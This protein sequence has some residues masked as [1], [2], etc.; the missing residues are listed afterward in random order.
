MA[1]RFLPNIKVA[2]RGTSGNSGE[3]FGAFITSFQFDIGYGNEKSTLSM[4][5]ENESGSYP[6]LSGYKS[7]LDSYRISVDRVATMYM[8]LVAEEESI[9]ATRSTLTLSFVDGSH[10]LDRIYIGLLGEHDYSDAAREKTTLEAEIPIICEGCTPN[11]FLDKIKVTVTPTGYKYAGKAINDIDFANLVTRGVANPDELPVY[12]SKNLVLPNKNSIVKEG[13][14]IILGDEG[15]GASDCSIKTSDYS[16]TQLQSVLNSLNPAISTDIKI[17]AST[18]GQRAINKDLNRFR[19]GYTGTLRNVLKNWC[20]DFGVSFVYDC[21]SNTPN[22]KQIDLGN[23]KLSSKISKIKNVAKNIKSTSASEAVVEGITSSSTLEG[24]SKKF[25]ASK[26]VN[27]ETYKSHNSTIYFQTLY[28]GIRIQD[29]GY[30]SYGRTEQEFLISCA[31]AKYNRELRTIYNLGLALQGFM[32]IPR[33]GILRA[34]GFLPQVEIPHLLKQQVLNS[35]GRSDYMQV[36]KVFD[37]TGT[38]NFLMAV[39]LYSEDLDNQE[40]EYEK[41]VAET[42]IGQHF[43]TNLQE[44]GIPPICPS[45]EQPNKVKL[46]G[47]LD[48]KVQKVLAATANTTFE[49]PGGSSQEGNYNFPFANILRAPIPYNKFFYDPSG[50]PPFVNIFSRRNAAYYPPVDVFNSFFE[51]YNPMAVGGGAN[52][53]GEP[54]GN[55]GKSLLQFLLPKYVDLN[56]TAAGFTLKSRFPWNFIG[57]TITTNLG[58]KLEPKLFLAPNAAVI[59]NYVRVSPLQYA[60]NPVDEGYMK[61][62]EKEQPK[63][64]ECSTSSFIC[65]KQKSLVSAICRDRCVNDINNALPTSVNLEATDNSGKPYYQMFGAKKDKWPEGIFDL[66][67]A[68]N[69]PESNMFENKQSYGFQ[70]FFTHPQFG[71][72]RA[73]VVFPLSVGPKN[74]S[75]GANYIEKAEREIFLPK[76]QDIKN[77]FTSMSVGN[78]SRVEVDVID[79]SAQMNYLTYD[80]TLNAGKL[81]LWIPGDGNFKSHQDYFNF[82]QWLNGQEVLPQEQLSITVAGVV[83]GSLQPYLKLSEGLQQYNISIGGEGFTTKLN[84]QTRPTVLPSKDMMSTFVGPRIIR[85]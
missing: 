76:L 65:E 7:Y 45:M 6:D 16:F 58:L 46:E 84:F 81:N 30:A 27:E 4:T 15:F 51:T 28:G 55:T 70:I 62:V 85:K 67:Q 43:A 44:G 29:I 83:L 14:I 33:Y 17:S 61:D 21:F 35:F 68:Q 11:T 53:M 54:Q 24:T 31:L 73:D 47:E 71:L 32:G 22:V 19:R 9:S 52:S 25:I 75:Y 41:R 72:R 64:E 2:G 5:L 20:S 63:E 60:L 42:F 77:S 3:A 66:S 37:P 13:G 23:N 10:I 78:V 50:N 59:G 82:L 74:S 80:P 49:G 8:Y 26:F 48:P 69:D 18:A 1:I 12:K 34:L 56:N 39:G 38:N 79:S 57:Q 36:A 40:Y